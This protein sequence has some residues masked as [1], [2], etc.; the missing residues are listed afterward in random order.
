M[1]VCVCVYIY[2]CMYTLLDT[3]LRNARAWALATS[4]GV[5]RGPANAS[6]R[7]SYAGPRLCYS[8]LCII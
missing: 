2:I 6:A 5:S 3:N 8:V 7:T 1:Y 4:S